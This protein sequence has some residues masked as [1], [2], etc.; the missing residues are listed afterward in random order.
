[1]YVCVCMVEGGGLSDL[2]CLE[3]RVLVDV[4]KSH[5]SILKG[6]P[7]PLVPKKF[8]NMCVHAVFMQMS[9]PVVD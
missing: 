1:M 6:E 4:L 5:R 9:H 8:Q 3:F 2:R 7:T